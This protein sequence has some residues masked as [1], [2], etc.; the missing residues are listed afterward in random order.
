[1]AR[2]SARPPGGPGGDRTPGG[3]EG[4]GGAEGGPARIC[5][6]VARDG[7]Q[8]GPSSG[9][10]EE[11]WVRGVRVVSRCSWKSSR[12]DAR[13]K[14]T[15]A[16][17][18]FRL[19]LHNGN[20]LLLRAGQDDVPDVHA[21]LR[22]KLGRAPACVAG[23]ITHFQRVAFELVDAQ[24]G[25]VALLELKG[26]VDLFRV[27]ARVDLEFAGVHGVPDGRD[28]AR[29]ALNPERAL[30]GQLVAVEDELVPSH[31]VL[32]QTLAAP[33]HRVDV[34]GPLQQLEILLRAGLVRL[35]L[36]SRRLAHGGTSVPLLPN[37]RDTTEQN[38]GDGNRQGLADFCK[39]HGAYHSCDEIL[40]RD[41][42]GA[43]RGRAG[44]G[45]RRMT[46]RGADQSGRYLS[47]RLAVRQG[48]DQTRDRKSHS[49][50]GQERAETSPAARHARG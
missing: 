45:V 42:D 48:R 18:L 33:F 9:R 24:E 15:A 35:L 44:G 40:N 30:P 17:F 5:L 22:G 20:A 43:G 6:P 7:R 28:L 10:S 27:L 13:R 50:P 26:D 25:P 14:P 16:R 8:P 12:L 31:Q 46:D 39:S 2:P 38:G 41:R 19:R 36:L 3:G 21:L 37:Q 1:M 49:A 47:R 34:P 11:W 23:E 4:G 29:F 32:G